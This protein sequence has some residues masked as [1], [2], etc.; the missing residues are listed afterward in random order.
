MR[1]IHAIRTLLIPL[2]LWSSASFAEPLAF[3]CNWAA[4]G[5]SNDPTRLL[6][7]RALQ[8]DVDAQARTFKAYN[9]LDGKILGQPEFLLTDT[10][11]KLEFKKP[12]LA[13][14]V[15]KPR[16]IIWISRFDFSSSISLEAA[17]MLRWYRDGSCHRRQF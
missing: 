9:E 10:S 6:I 12:S 15:D 17:S 11:L 3:S 1:V 7:D 13:G 5:T 14:D 16:I 4:N 2:L 8:F